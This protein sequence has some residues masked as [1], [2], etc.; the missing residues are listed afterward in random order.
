M[1]GSALPL[2]QILQKANITK[3][4]VAKQVLKIIEPF[5]YKDDKSK[6]E[7]NILPY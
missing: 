7:I 5:H 4:S 6:I 3:Q 2:V 1:D